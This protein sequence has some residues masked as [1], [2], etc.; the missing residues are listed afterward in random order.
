M[1]PSDYSTRVVRALSNKIRRLRPQRQPNAVYTYVSDGADL[2]AA[3][4]ERV[5]AWPICRPSTA[6]QC[7]GASIERF[8]LSAREVLLEH[9]GACRC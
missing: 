9:P 8:C 4:A 3:I 2:E 7:G 6:R 5:L 1:S